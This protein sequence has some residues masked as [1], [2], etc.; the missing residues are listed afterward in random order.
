[1]MRYTGKLRCWSR[2]VGIPQNL[3]LFCVPDG[4]KLARI[5]GVGETGI[6]DLYR[7]SRADVD[8]VVV[9]HKFVGSG[10]GKGSTR[11][12][13]T[14]DGKQGSETWTQ[15]SG[16]L[17]KAVGDQNALDVR[18]AFDAGRVETWV[19]TTRPNGSTIVE[20]LDA[21]GKPK[22]V[23]TSKILTGLNLSGAQL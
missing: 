4:E 22:P 15:G 7:V 23:D 17:E 10:T 11:L 9:E 13:D 20:V 18:L 8:Y 16:R 6:D 19:V 1:M 3:S 21:F 14:A 5:P 2:F 12:G